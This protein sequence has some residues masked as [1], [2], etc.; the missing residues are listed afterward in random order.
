MYKYKYIYIYIYIY[1]YYKMGWRH[2][3]VGKNTA[4]KEMHPATPWPSSTGAGCF[5]TKQNSGITHHV[6]ASVTVG[7]ANLKG[8]KGGH[9]MML[10]LIFMNCPDPDMPQ[11]DLMQHR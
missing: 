3:T 10:L 6:K 4:R 5:I 2:V 1:T 7:H 11:K 8:D 9:V